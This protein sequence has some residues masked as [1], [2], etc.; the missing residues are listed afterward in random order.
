[1]EN[2]IKVPINSKNLFDIGTQI[3]EE[4]NY[5]TPFLLKMI[6]KHKVHLAI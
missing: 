3:N 4:I 5:I 2:E 6:A 1:M